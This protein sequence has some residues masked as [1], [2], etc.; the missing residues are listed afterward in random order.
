MINPRHLGTIKEITRDFFK[1]TTFDVEISFNSPQGNTIP[2]NIKTEEPR[3]LIGEKGRTLA[4]LQHLLKAMLKKEVEEDFYIDL[5]VN[6]YKEKKIKYLKEL[7]TSIADEVAL[8]REEKVLPP[9]PA[10]ERRV[11]HLELA[12]R[13]D[14]TTESIGKEPNRKVTIKPYP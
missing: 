4:Q 2:I 8:M 7:A 13:A 14:V 10:Y 9:M 12:E 5:D 3:A 1:K 6:G 11:I